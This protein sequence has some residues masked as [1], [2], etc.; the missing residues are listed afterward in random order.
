MKDD[1]PNKNNVYAWEDTWPGWCHNHLSLG[2]CRALIKIACKHYKVP[3]P[4]VTQHTNGTYAWSAPSFNRISMQGGEHM[5]RGS[6]NVSTVMHEVA[7]HVGWHLHGEHIQD[8]GPTFVGIFIDC[9]VMAKVAPRVAL[10]A[11]ARSCG[12]R[13]SRTKRAPRRG[14]G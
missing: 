14:G 6:R 10:E 4:T 11:S 12:L 1:D 8:H 2:Q 5:H 13:W 9:L 3:C 7:H